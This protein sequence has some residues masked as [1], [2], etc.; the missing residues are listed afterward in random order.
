MRRNTTLIWMALL[1]AV[2]AWGQSA[3]I[4]GIVTDTSDAVMSGVE[5]T[6][7][8]TSTGV[9]RRA[10]SNESGNYS[11]P[12]LQPGPYRITA[13]ASGF[14]PLSRD[15]INLV[16]DQVA[17][18]DIQMEVG[19]V[20]E[21]IE[22]VSDATMVD[23]SNATLGVVVENRRVVDLPLNGRNALA[24]VMLTPA[25]ISQ[26]GPTNSGFANRGTA[27]SAVSINGG[28]GVFNNYVLDG[29]N[30]NQAQ[31][32]DINVQPAVDAVEEFKVQHN[33]M[34]AEYGFTLGGVVNVVTKSGTNDPHGALYHFLRN[35]KFDARNTF[36]DTRAP[37]RYNQFG[38]SLG[39]P[40]V[41]P[42]IYSGMNR[43][44]F[45]T[46][47]EEWRYR[48]YEN[49]II[50]VPTAAEREGDFS[51]LRAASGALIPIFDPLTTRANPSG[52]GFIRDPFADNRIPQNRIDPVS[53]NV[54]PFYPLPNRA[55]SDPFTNAN[56]YLS[57]IDET[58]SMRQLTS[59]LD[60]RISDSNSIYGRYTYYRHRTDGGVG[61]SPYPDPLVRQRIDNFV[62][63]NLIVNN[64]HTINPA[65]INEFRAGLARS[66]F[67]FESL[68]YGKNIPQQL[69]LPASVPPDTF[70]SIGNGMTSFGTFYAGLRGTVIFQV[71][72]MV[73]LTRGNHTLKAG[74]EWRKLQ[75][76]NLNN[77]NPSGSYT[78]AA[79][80]TGN[81]QQPGGTGFG[82]ATFLTGSV[83]SASLTRYL[84]ASNLGSSISGFIQDDWKVTRRLSLSLGLR[85]DYQTW[86]I[87]RYDG[88]S[89]FNPLAVNPENNLMG[90]MEYAGV[91]FGRSVREPDYNN[92]GPRLGFALDI[93][94]RGATV[95]RG[96]YSIF[97]PQLVNNSFYGNTAGFATAT[98]NYQPP[99][100]NA[101]LPAFQFSEGLP[102]PPIAPLGAALGPSAFLGQNVTYE[103]SNA[104]VPMS[105]QWGLSLQQRLKGWRFEISYSANR[106]S[107]MAAGNYDLNQLDPQH[108]ALG[109][110]LQN[111]VANPYA[112]IVPGSLGSAT[113]TRLQ[114][115]RPLPY[116]N[117]VAVFRPTLGSSM[118]NAM[119]LSVERRLSSG[120]SILLSYTNGKLLSDSIQTTSIGS[121]QGG[122]TNYQNGK[123]NRAAEWSLDPTDVSQRLVISGLYELPFGRGKR[124]SFS[125]GVL[126]GFARGWQANIISTMQSGLPI[127]VRGANNFL[128]DRPNSTG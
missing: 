109:L 99:G 64:T 89:N 87:D 113:I 55:P 63:H 91:D 106:V 74:G 103:E 25:V 41:L 96:G 21:L 20:T 90:R 9:S 70:P 31:Q 98:T 112:G 58:Q 14:K 4:T 95:L 47:Y 12:L 102:S 2:P 119:L 11:V 51:N 37:F 57:T 36:A 69:G 94:G 29:G 16:V 85:Y 50:R 97:Y 124:W 65:T 32:A 121:E 39:G 40:I 118:Y 5:I 56:N 30:N 67:P 45:F 107:H 35:D 71:H 120:F 42:R 18:I 28:P 92:W 38:G 44:F 26:A 80:L 52:S 17:R 105:Q 72:D 49:P 43:S 46:N 6:V 101:N 22:V 108:L 127:L 83:S 23:S 79:G 68:S 60:H 62:T 81:P 122:V 117:Q 27:L 125:H 104:R 93:T 3:R 128:A 1:C 34:S 7:T 24:L 13:Q 76:N 15:G 116:Y 53:R 115:L 82:F 86:P 110:A 10:V 54:L 88:I 77:T 111:Q 114:S 123:F 33:S 61:G 59:K 19:Q 73:T 126:D 78:F 100:N 48:R 75:A 66:Y 8:N 84:G